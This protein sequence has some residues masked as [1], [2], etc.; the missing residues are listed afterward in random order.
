MY[1]IDYLILIT[2][3]IEKRYFFSI[4]S[5]A[6]LVRIIKKYDAIFYFFS[7]LFKNLVIS[8]GNVYQISF[9]CLL[10]CCNSD[11]NDEMT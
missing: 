1:L 4:A 8:N 10:Y 5:L 3:V 6:N 11:K 9:A 2:S 7:L